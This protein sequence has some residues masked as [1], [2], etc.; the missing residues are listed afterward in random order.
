M[1]RRIARGPAG[2]QANLPNRTGFAFRVSSLTDLSV[3]TI[4]WL[5]M[6][7]C[8]TGICFVLVLTAIPLLTGC[9]EQPVEAGATPDQTITALTTALSQQDWDSLYDLAPPSERRIMESIWE[10]RR[11]DLEADL[12]SLAR[13]LGTDR[14]EV[15]EKDCRQ[16]FA[17]LMQKRRERELE[18][19]CETGCRF[20]R[21]EIQGIS[22]R[23]KCRGDGC[24]K[25]LV[26]RREQC[27]WYVSGLLSPLRVV[28]RGR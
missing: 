26:L 27:G 8:N 28:A 16:I 2:A 7:N 6:R 24:E 18:R 3:S 22:C 4:I 1:G 10:K 19:R 12:E 15:E 25:K 21:S 17:V 11:C 23:A 20:E 13:E 5:A 14:A 9:S